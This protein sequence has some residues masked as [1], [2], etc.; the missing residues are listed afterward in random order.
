MHVKDASS[1]YKETQVKTANQGKLIVMLYNG[2]IK[3]LKL[4]LENLPKKKYDIVNN[5]II[6]TQDIISELML[7]LNFEVGDFANKLYDLYSYINKRLVEGNIKKSAEP[8][9]EVIRY[10]VELK[11]AWEQI[12]HVS[13]Y[14]DQA[15]VDLDS[16]GGV[17]ICS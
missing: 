3:F 13:T 5:N 8:L 1:H 4:A 17:N 6:K 14:N 15:N 16:D 10:L 12:S 9:E 2:A 11:K 7:S